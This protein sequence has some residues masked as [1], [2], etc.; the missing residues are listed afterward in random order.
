MMISNK[1]KGS[2]HWKICSLAVALI[3]LAAF[4][5]SLVAIVREGA[6]IEKSLQEKGRTALYSFENLFGQQCGDGAGY[7]YSSG[8]YRAKYCRY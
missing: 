5:T 1:F 3:M 4:I 2:L 7:G 8:H 6:Y